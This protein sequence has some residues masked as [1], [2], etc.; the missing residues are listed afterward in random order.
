MK[1]FFTLIAMAFMALSVNA[2]EMTLW[3]GEAL[4]NGWGN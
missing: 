2:T 3:E 4:V 1:K